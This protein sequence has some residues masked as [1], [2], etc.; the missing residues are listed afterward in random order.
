MTVVEHDRIELA[1]SD[2]EVPLDELFEWLETAPEGHKSEVVGGVLY[3]VPQRDTHWDIIQSIVLALVDRFGR[4]VKVK[5]DV[6]IDFPGHR[7]AFCPDVAKI[8]DDAV[9]NDKGRWNY[10]DVEFIAEVISQGTG[11]NDYGP[12]KTAYATAGVPVYLI[13]DPYTGRCIAH[14]KPEDGEYTEEVRVPFG[15]DLDLTKT[16]LD[17]VLKTDEF[18]RD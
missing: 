13:V 12:K 15:T 14:T 8:R 18:P 5:S 10:E 3:T 1:M 2:R 9:K 16:P 7:N 6:R 4:G 11:M 17:L